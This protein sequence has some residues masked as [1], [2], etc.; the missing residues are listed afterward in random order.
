MVLGEGV[1][2]RAAARP[3]RPCRSGPRS[4]CAVQRRPRR[5]RR[6]R[7][8]PA[9]SPPP[10]KPACRSGST[11]RGSRSPTCR[12]GFSAA[13]LTG[14][15]ELKNNG[16]TGA[17]HRPGE[18]VGRRS[19]NGASAR[20]GVERHE[21]FLGGAFGQR[22]IDRRPGRRTVGLGNGGARR[23]SR[24]PAS[25]P[26]ALAGFI[27][28]ADAIGKRH[29]CGQ[30]RGFRPGDRSGR[31]LRGAP[32]RNRLH[33]C[34][35]RPARAAGHAGS[36]AATIEADL[37]VDLNKRRIAAV[38]RHRLRTGRGGAGRLGAGRCASARRPGRG[39]RSGPST[40]SRWRSS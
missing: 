34:R 30:D 16:G 11:A 4:S 37:P 28:R 20:A 19:G 27:A 22:Q 6:R 25:I 26:D 32:R 39:R 38:G 3:G 36:A 12:R 40:A 7:L 15:F 5:L 14:L 2:R 1:A 31:V 23:L 17:F 35:R 29:R 9:R 13:R 8:R 18:A 10:T 33:R 24:S 21:R